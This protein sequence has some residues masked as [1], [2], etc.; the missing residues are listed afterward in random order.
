MKRYFLKLDIDD[1]EWREVS[2]AQFIRAEHQ[3]GFRGGSRKRGRTAT[4]SFTGGGVCGRVKYGGITPAAP[5]R[6]TRPANSDPG[7]QI[8]G[9]TVDGSVL[10]PCG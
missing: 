6:A 10:P 3:A 4:A 5:D 8:N 1:D 2:L 9:A 7:E